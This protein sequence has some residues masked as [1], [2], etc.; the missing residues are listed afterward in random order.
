MTLKAR[1]GGEAIA[2]SAG[3]REGRLYTC[4]PSHPKIGQRLLF[5][6]L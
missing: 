2:V 4:Q 3:S 6:G 1:R 5:L